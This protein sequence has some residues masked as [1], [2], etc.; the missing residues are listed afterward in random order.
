[1]TNSMVAGTLAGTAGGSIYAA[2]MIGSFLAQADTGSVGVNKLTEFG[3][4]GSLMAV[5][6]YIVYLLLNR[7]LTGRESDL[8]WHRE[9]MAR[10]TTLFQAVIDEQAK[11][12]ERN[13]SH[14]VDKLSSS[15]EKLE[16]R[17]GSRSDDILKI[18]EAMRAVNLVMDDVKE[19]LLHCRDVQ[20][21]RIPGDGKQ[22]V[23]REERKND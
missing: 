14:L 12:N 19:M 17:I 13:M 6:V 7:T 22:G 21:V 23:A 11:L 3:V 10:R 15:L 8:A 4:A 9:E 5:I 18:L 16:A 2:W 20:R 1:M